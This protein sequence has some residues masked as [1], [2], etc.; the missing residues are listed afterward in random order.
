LQRLVAAVRVDS[1]TVQVIDERHN[2]YKFPPLTLR[3]PAMDS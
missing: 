2:C 1:G 3:A